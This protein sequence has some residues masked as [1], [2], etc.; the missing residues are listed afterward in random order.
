MILVDGEIA[1][2]KSWT[3]PSL[4]TGHAIW[5]GRAIYSTKFFYSFQ[6]AYCHMLLC[7]TVGFGKLPAKL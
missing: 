1:S 6:A 7:S 3:T 5:T 2:T 4:W